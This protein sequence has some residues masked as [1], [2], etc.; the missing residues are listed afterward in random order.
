L[1]RRWIGRIIVNNAGRG[2]IFELS[3]TR[4]IDG[5]GKAKH[6]I[7]RLIAEGMKNEKIKTI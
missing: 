4:F 5:A 6:L 3:E 1:A 7:H 2:V